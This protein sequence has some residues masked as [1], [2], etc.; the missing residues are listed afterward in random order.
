MT[1]QTETVW[2]LDY[3]ETVQPF[4]LFCLYLS[5]WGVSP[6]GRLII[7]LPTLFLCDSLLTEQKNSL[8][9]VPALFSVCMSSGS[10]VSMF[11]GSSLRRYSAK[12]QTHTRVFVP[13]KSCDW[14]RKEERKSRCCR[15]FEKSRNS[16]PAKGRT[17][18]D[19]LK[20]T[21]NLSVSA[22]R[23]EK[24]FLWKILFVKF[25]ELSSTLV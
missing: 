9:D 5:K 19:F 21:I 12:A 11:F 1:S 20:C 22:N 18:K 24:I 13:L 2:Q 6:C 3:S 15:I 16:N 14:Y 7:L 25:S 17:E 4:I 23:R 8:W 10:F